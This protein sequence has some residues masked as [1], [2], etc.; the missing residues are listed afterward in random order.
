MLTERAT[1]TFTTTG[2]RLAHPLPAEHVTRAGTAPRR[3]PRDA[4]AYLLTEALRPWRAGGAPMGLELSGG[5]DSATAAIA[6][7]E[8]A[9][10][11]LRTFGLLV[12]GGQA[13]TK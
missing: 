7:H 12:E 2:L 1:A 11:P 8:P 3:R 6:A 4:L 10:P 13:A 5:L 9:G